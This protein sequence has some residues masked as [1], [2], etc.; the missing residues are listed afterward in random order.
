MLAASLIVTALTTLVTG[1]AHAIAGG[2]APDALLLAAAFVATLLVLSPLLRGRPSAARQVLA[3]AVAQA[4]QHMLYA[5]PETASSAPAAHM[6][7]AD[8]ALPATTVHAHASMP[9]AHV[10]AGLLT[11]ALLRWVP[12]AVAAMQEAMSLRLAAAVLTWAPANPRRPAS[13]VAAHRPR[14]TALDALACVRGT[15]GPPALLV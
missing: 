2:A 4:L 3:V 1:L 11:L 15:R 8:G 12:R 13:V 14:R 6:H 5:L 10:A 9:L 7:G